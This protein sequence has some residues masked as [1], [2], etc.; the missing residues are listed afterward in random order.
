MAASTSIECVQF[1]M[2]TTGLQQTPEKQ[3]FTQL[4][5]PFLSCSH[6]VKVHIQKLCTKEE[7]IMRN[8]HQQFLQILNSLANSYMIK[9]NKKRSKD[10]KVKC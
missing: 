3:N 2:L 6:I 10:Y 1:K 8:A 7:S 5:P 9:E 4:L